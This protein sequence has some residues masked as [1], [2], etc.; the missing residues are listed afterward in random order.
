MVIVRRSA[1][2]LALLAAAVAGACT[3]FDKSPPKNTCSTDNDCY[4][5]QGEHCDTTAHTCVMLDAGSP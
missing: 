3:L 2:V 5:A 4:R 1:L